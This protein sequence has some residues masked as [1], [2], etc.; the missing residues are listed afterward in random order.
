MAKILK[1]GIS[2]TEADAVDQKV[3]ETVE[4]ILDDVRQRGEAAIRE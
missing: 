3:R 1:E 4:T 2:P